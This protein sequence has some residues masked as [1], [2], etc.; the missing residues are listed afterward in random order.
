MPLTK[1]KTQSI[2]RQRGLALVMS[3][4]ILLVLTLLGV[5]AMNTSNLQ[6][7]MTGNSQYQTTAL[8]KAES[9]LRT[10][11]DVISDFI[12]TPGATYPASGYYN[13]PGGAA[14]IDLATFDW[15]DANV[16]LIPG[17]PSKY[18]IEFTGTEELDS[19]S[20]AW[21][22]DQGI[23]GDD[24]SVFRITART[25][26]TRGAVRYVQSIFVTISAPL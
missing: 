17:E 5:T 2:S 24:V 12:G 19:A 18:I 25:P 16:I 21:R 3:L 14:P 13:I 22:Q 4:V 7:L 6:I 9:V 10:A 1:S 11:E 26:S 20:K 8:N 15:D 23:I